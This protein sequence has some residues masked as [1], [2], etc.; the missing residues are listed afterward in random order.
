MTVDEVRVK[1]RQ[2]IDLVG[3]EKAVVTLII[4]GKSWGR[5]TYV[6]LGSGMPMGRIVGDM[7]DRP[8]VIAMF[9]AEALLAALGGDE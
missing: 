1:C 9:Q 4:P 7:M 6:R 2:Q 3:P 5:R 8:G